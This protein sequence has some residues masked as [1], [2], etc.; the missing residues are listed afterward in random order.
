MKAQTAKESFFIGELAASAGVKPDTIRF[1]EKEK[2]LPPPGRTAAGYVRQWRK[3]ARS[4][5]KMAAEFCALIE[6]PALHARERLLR[7]RSGNM[8]VIG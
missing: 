2:L 6:S 3:A 1:Y 8:P 4:G 5:S 7:R